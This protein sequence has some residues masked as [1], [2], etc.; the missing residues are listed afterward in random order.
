MIL[1]R[2][3]AAPSDYLAFELIAAKYITEALV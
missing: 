1:G 3:K 2:H